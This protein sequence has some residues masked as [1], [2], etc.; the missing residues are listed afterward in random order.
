MWQEIIAQQQLN[1]DTRVYISA[2]QKNIDIFQVQTTLG[3]FYARHVVLAMGRR[4]TPRKL[5]VPGEELAKVA[6]QLIDAQSYQQ[7]QLLVVGGGDS[8]VEAAIGLARQ[9]GNKVT[10]SYR[11][12]KFFRIKKKNEDRSNEM[13]SSKKLTALFNS[14][15]LEIKEKSVIIKTE[16]GT[17]EIPNDYVFIFAGGVPPFQMLKEMGIQFGGETKTA[18]SS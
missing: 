1:I 6:Y 13:I 12:D 16:K 17:V 14:Q 8:A 9:P 2:I 4:G 7:K 10:I 15:V 18:I 3:I 11:K 5:E